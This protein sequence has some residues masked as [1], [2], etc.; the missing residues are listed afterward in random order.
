MNSCEPSRGGLCVVMQC[1][2]R[3]GEDFRIPGAVGVGAVGIGAVGTGGFESLGAVLGSELR[4]STKEECLLNHRIISP[5]PRENFLV[6][7]S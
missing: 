1:L 2:Q 6:Q 7:T 5:A 4:T 3:P